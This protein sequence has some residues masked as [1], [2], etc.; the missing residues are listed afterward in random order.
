MTILEWRCLKGGVNRYSLQNPLCD[1]NK[2]R[3][4]FCHPRGLLD[5]DVGKHA[6]Q[7]TY[8]TTSV[9]SQAIL[10]GEHIVQSSNNKFTYERFRGCTK[11]LTPP[12]LTRR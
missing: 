7:I 2:R 11:P 8:P 3:R 5:E 12:A 10:K 6:K 4:R 1:F 9:F